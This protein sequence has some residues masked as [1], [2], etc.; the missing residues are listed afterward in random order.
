MKKFV[1]SMMVL[2]AA[3]LM[4]SCSKEQKREFDKCYSISANTSLDAK[5]LADG[6]KITVIWHTTNGDGGTFETKVSNHYYKPNGTDSLL[7]I[8]INGQGSPDGVYI[9][10]GLNNNNPFITLFFDKTGKTLGTIKPAYGSSHQIW[11]PMNYAEF[12]VDQNGDQTVIS[13]NGLD[14]QSEKPN[15]MCLQIIIPITEY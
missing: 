3:T 7:R 12:G 4:T 6:K 5:Q 1:F 15:Y 8:C 13:A 11:N 9:Q 10:E 14:E 2:C